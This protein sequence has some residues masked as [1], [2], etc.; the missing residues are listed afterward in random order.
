MSDQ[1]DVRPQ[2]EVLR[3]IDSKLPNPIILAREIGEAIRQVRGRKLFV[4]W[5]PPEADGMTFGGS[6]GQTIYLSGQYCDAQAY[7]GLDLRI[8]ARATG[9]L[10]QVVFGCT[11]GNGYREGII[12]I[13]LPSFT[14]L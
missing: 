5:P 11:E 14:V 6:G 9:R 12:P 7:R 8:D 10:L 2:V 1:L 3:S 13:E 4:N